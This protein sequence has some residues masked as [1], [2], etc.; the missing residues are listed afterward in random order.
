MPRITT[1]HR[2]WM[3][4]SRLIHG[5]SILRT[6]NRASIIW[7]L[8]CSRS[9]PTSHKYYESILTLNRGITA[10]DLADARQWKSEAKGSYSAS[11][12]FPSSRSSTAAYISTS[13]ASGAST[14]H[15][16]V[17]H[18]RPDMSLSESKLPIWV[19]RQLDTSDCLHKYLSFTFFVNTG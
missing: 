12:K 2:T 5:I 17:H 18:A 6:L 19:S 9:V 1:S 11:T 14:S 7:P 13:L 16:L 4:N 15:Q 3:A 10:T 8:V